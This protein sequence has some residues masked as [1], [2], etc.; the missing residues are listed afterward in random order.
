MSRT[1]ERS[2]ADSRTNR[3][4]I[5]RLGLY[6][7]LDADKPVRFMDGTFG[8]SPSDQQDMLEI[9]AEFNRMAATRPHI[10]G[11]LSAFPL[12]G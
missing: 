6:D 11:C 3:R 12:G 10:T 8:D 4:T 2:T 5:Y 7:P 1:K 9:I